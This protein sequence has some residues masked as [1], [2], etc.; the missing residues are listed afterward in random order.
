MHAEAEG[1]APARGRIREAHA[2]LVAAQQ[3]RE[4]VAE[5]PGE[6][7]RE[8]PARDLGAGVAGTDLLQGAAAAEPDGDAGAFAVL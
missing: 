3:A 4:L 6:T 2:E 8:A 7:G 1:S 5:F